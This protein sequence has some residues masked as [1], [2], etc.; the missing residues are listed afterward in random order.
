MVQFLNPFLPL[1]HIAMQH[2][3]CNASKRG[4]DLRKLHGFVHFSFT[5]SAARLMRRAK[6]AVAL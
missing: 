3:F 6:V 4:A 1:L 5:Y 2:D